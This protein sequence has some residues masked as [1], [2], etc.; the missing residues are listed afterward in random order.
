MKIFTIGLVLLVIFN[1]FAYPAVF[2]QGDDEDDDSE[3]D[4]VINDETPANEETISSEEASADDDDETV[5]SRSSPF[6]STSLLFIKPEKLEFPAG[7][8][9]KLVVGFQN[10]GT[11]SFIVDRIEASL[12]YPQDFSYEIQ[13][14]T[15]YR[16]GKVVES[17]REATFEYSFTPSETFSSRPFGLVI[18]LNYRNLE[19]TAFVN[20][21]F[22]DT[23]NIIEPDEGFDGETFF[24]YVFLLAIAVIL[25][26]IAQ[27]F[28]STSFKKRISS[29]IQSV[30]KSTNG[31][32]S[33][34]ASS[35]G[36]VDFGWIPKEHLQTNKSPKNSP[37]QRKQPASSGSE[38]EN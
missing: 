15:A 34:A 23:I 18:N 9:V 11:S 22:N 3:E 25:V 6:V 5:V 31:G 8:L 17:E 12:R 24:L 20:G 29:K 13:N 38:N 30:Q 1:L 33:A 2:A 32:S 14:F 16:Y 26:V 28:F 27:Q 10:N 37:R 36:D 7:K 35:N 4:A 21:L 19:G